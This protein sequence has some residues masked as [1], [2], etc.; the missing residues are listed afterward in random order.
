MTKNPR[1]NIMM[2]NTSELC[3]ETGNQL[4]RFK[5]TAAVAEVLLP[6]A[7]HTANTVLWS[8]V[9]DLLVRISSRTYAK[10]DTTTSH[11]R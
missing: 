8:N 5:G 6:A 10:Y 2:K 4:L 11:R 7:G 1:S 9:C 3:S